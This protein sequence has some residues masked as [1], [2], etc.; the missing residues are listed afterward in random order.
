MTTDDAPAEGHEHDHDFD[1]SECT[2]EEAKEAI[3]E[4]DFADE[5]LHAFEQRERETESRVTLTEWLADRHDYDPDAVTVD[6]DEAPAESAVAPERTGPARE[7]D[8]PTVGDDDYDPATDSAWAP[9]EVPTPDDI[10][11]VVVVPPAEGMFAGY[12]FE[13]ARPKVVARNRR[14]DRAIVDG[15]LVYRGTAP[16]DADDGETL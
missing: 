16:A 7:T 4:G 9:G 8:A 14:V 13:G 2:V 10:P 12:W 11:L 1:I 3:R 6:T 15:P 5:Q